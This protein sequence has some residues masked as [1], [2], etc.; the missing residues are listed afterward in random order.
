M[1]VIR[2][3]SEWKDRW[4]AFIDDSRNGTFHLKR[5]FVEY[6][7]DRFQDHS[8]IVTDESG[9]W[10]TVIAM[11][12]EGL[13]AHSHKGL[14]YAGFVFAPS[15][16]L[17][18]NFSAMRK[19]LEYLAAHG[20]ETFYYKTIPHIYHRMPAEDDLFFLFQ[21][22]AS[23]AVRHINPVI[24]Q[25]NKLPF[26][27]RRRRAIKKAQKAGLVVQESDRI[28]DYWDIVTDVLKYHGSTPVHAL[29]EI[30]ALHKAFP[31]SIKLFAAFQGDVMVGGVLIF[32]SETVAKLQYIGA[33]LQGKDIGAI[34]CIVD[35][36]VNER[37]R[38]IAYI[39]FGTSTG[40]GGAFV[41]R[42]I[43][44]Q[45]EGFGARTT[46]HDHVMI[47]IK[48]LDWSCLDAAMR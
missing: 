8:L 12:I 31:Q 44:D 25:S 33:S 30:A 19:V 3:S 39:D 16:G 1:N 34:D 27:E 21:V 24:D 14:S 40:S 15:F 2:Y 13:A 35:F 42:G 36:L 6:H 18:D 4:D 28:A 43:S 41:S 7:G 46:V 26:Q 5:A 10:I 17:T 22:K 32:E 38:D 37:Y 29:H 45:K 9:N 48:G 23:L 11:C 20:V 47:D